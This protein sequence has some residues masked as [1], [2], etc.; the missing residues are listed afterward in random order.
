[1][2]SAARFP[3]SGVMG[4]AP[5]RPDPGPSPQAALRPG[6]VGAGR[7]LAE[8]SYL[9][10]F[11]QG[12][13]VQAKG[14]R[15]VQGEV[16]TVLRRLY[17]EYVPAIAAGR[18][19]TGVHAERQY[20]HFNPPFDIPLEGLWRGLNAYL[21]WD[22]RVHR[23]WRVGEAV[24]A[25]NSVLSKTYRYT[26]QTGGILS[27]FDALTVH[28]WYGPLDEGLMREAAAL[29]P[30]ERDFRPFTVQPG[31]YTSTVRHLTRFDLKRSGRRLVFAVSADGFM[32]HMVRRLVGTVVEVGRGARPVEWV[33]GLVER[34]E[35]EA[36]PPIDGR[37]LCL[38]EVVYPPLTSFPSA[39]I[40]SP[41][42]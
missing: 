33:R 17:K 19:D 14:E 26:L 15:T 39:P 13:Q 21:P 27:P 28:A 32:R 38:A 12:W 29:L 9:G 6:L 1:L 16:E 11:F 24:H 31:G 42:A 7:I 40:I 4:E 37:G 41:L 10:A 20:F 23:T 3:Y 8:C 25:R 34:G 5:Q 18:T 35:G 2:T 36:G 22:I 30:G